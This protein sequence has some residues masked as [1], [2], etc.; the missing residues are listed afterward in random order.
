VLLRLC[1]ALDRAAAL[2]LAGLL[3]VMVLAVSWQIVSRY[4]LGDPSGWTEE[5]ARFLLI[6]IGLFGGAFA[7]QR[8]LHLG[9]DL[10]AER[11]QGN[12]R[13]WHA[14]FVDLCVLIF[15]V[16]ILIGG[17]LSLVTLTH[18]LEQFSPALGLPMAIVYLS[19]P[20]S[21]ALMAIFALTA[22][23]HARD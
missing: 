10:L 12:A 4:L 7:Y 6:W 5:L 20:L 15:A 8:R 1:N 17:G 18:E 16:A 11:L 19:L 13:R 2:L 14:R 22:L 21:G 3:V 9:L 23:V